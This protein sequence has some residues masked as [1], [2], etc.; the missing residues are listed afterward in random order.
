MIRLLLG[1]LLGAAVSS[2]WKNKGASG[3]SRAFVPGRVDELSSA[4]DNVVADPPVNVGDGT[5]GRTA[6]TGV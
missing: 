4:I 5:P 2:M 3:R 6:T 1:M